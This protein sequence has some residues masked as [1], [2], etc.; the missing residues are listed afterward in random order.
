MSFHFLSHRWEVKN[1]E[2]GILVTIG[3]QDMDAV[4]VDELFELFLESGQPNLYLDLRDVRLLASVRFSQ[5]ILL[6]I[7]LRRSGGRLVLCNLNAYI[8]EAMQAVRLTEIFDIRE[9]ALAEHVG[10]GDML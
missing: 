4:L 8:F 6:H 5:L 7:K 9:E 10:A 1:L 2:D 3:Q